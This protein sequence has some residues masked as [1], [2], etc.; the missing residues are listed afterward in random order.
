M[1]EELGAQRFVVR[2]ALGLFSRR[3]MHSGGFYFCCARLKL[4]G[5]VLNR[6]YALNRLYT[7]LELVPADAEGLG[8]VSL[9]FYLYSYPYPSIP[10][11]PFK[12]VVEI[13][14]TK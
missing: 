5:C 9:S 4:N 1:R 13:P 10:A 6:L 11:Y 3:R 12:P 2:F 14:S 8:G 7:Q